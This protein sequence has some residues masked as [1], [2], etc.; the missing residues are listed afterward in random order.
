MCTSKHASHGCKSRRYF[1]FLNHLG[2]FSCV[3]IMCGTCVMD[4]GYSISDSTYTTGWLEENAGGIETKFASIVEEMKSMEDWDG[5]GWQASASAPWFHGLTTPHLEQIPLIFDFRSN[6]GLWRQ[7]L[8]MQAWIQWVRQW[9]R[10]S[11]GL[12]QNC[13]WMGWDGHH[14]NRDDQILTPLFVSLHNP[15]ESTG[16]A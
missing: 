14:F 15:S 5:E 13:M 12:M 7:G 2:S 16:N 11:T 3:C 4:T 9:V 8:W 1:T 10:F 6:H